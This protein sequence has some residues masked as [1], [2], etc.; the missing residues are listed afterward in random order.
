MLTPRAS[1]IEFAFH[2]LDY[3]HTTAAAK[4]R[5]AGLPPGYAEGLVTGLWPSTDIL[6]A[7]E[8]AE[9]GI[10]INPPSYIWPSLRA[11]AE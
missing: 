8:V 5:D 6:P 11:A 3:D 9:T 10:E 7:R 4:M 1:G 2:A